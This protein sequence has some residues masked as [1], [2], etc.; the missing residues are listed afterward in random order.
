[1]MKMM[2]MML[3]IIAVL[4]ESV[5]VSSHASNSTVVCERGDERQT[6]G[7]RAGE[8]LYLPCPNLQ[9]FQETVNSSYVWFR[10]LNA[11]KQLER[12]GTEE[13][14]RVHHHESV[15]YILW[16]NLNDTGRYITRWWYEEG[17]CVEYETDVLVHEGFSTD[18]LYKT[19]PEQAPSRIECPVCEDVQ[20][21]I[22]WYKDFSLIP[23][24]EP[25]RYLRI[26]EPS[27][28]SEGV[29]TC[30]CVWEHRGVKLTSSGSRRLSI[31]PEAASG[32]PKFLLPIN[33]S[34][35]I[36]D[37]GWEVILNCSVF[38][39][40]TVCD[41]CSV[42]WEMNG[43]LLDG[44]DGYESRYR[45]TDGN[46]QSVLTI[47]SVSESD[48]GSEFRCKAK[49][50]TEVIFV[51]VTLKNRASVL[52]VL[53]AC[54]C[55]LLVFLLVGGITK[56]FALDL[57]LFLREIS[58]K[59]YSK[60]DGKMYDAYVIYQRSNLD[61]TT[62]KTVSDF[63]NGS[64]LTVL[65]N[66]YGFKLFIHGRDDLPG[67]D[68]MNLTEAKIRLSRRLIIL[69][70][71]GGS[72]EKSGDSPEAYDLQV[73]LHQALVQGEP[74]VILI[75]LGQTL[76]HARLPLGLQHLLWKSSPLLWRDGESSPNSRFWKRV[77]YRMPAASSH[78]RSRAKRSLVK[79]CPGLLV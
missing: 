65:E 69:L 21:S 49:D 53:L 6:R 48:L 75:Q 23:N 20:G 43:I 26:R 11:S 59:L 24:Q 39:G 22:V 74:A 68:C 27:R 9:C 3:Q 47:A 7:V 64:L 5:L 50:S 73:G 4:T 28:D 35:V 30:V 56:W 15:L 55:T 70:T 31:A 76:D 37:A 36:A 58:I 1:M 72:A 12:I 33:N 32:S 63:V 46:V 62:S 38:F 40:Q 19:L 79:S 77:R 14:E 52:P 42:H 25:G 67:E 29:Y 71:P 8:S 18:L 10:K 45:E 34:V 41:E 60:E 13:S 17:Q 78:R 51:S 54:F 66:Y 44:L 61:E 16:L 2:M 57:V